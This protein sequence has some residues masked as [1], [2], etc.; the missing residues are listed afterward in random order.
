MATKILPSSLDNIISS[1]LSE[2]LVYRRINEIILT[3]IDKNAN[4]LQ[5]ST[6][7]YRLFFSDER[8]RDPIYDLF[9]LTSD[10]INELIKKVPGINSSW[11][12][13][14]DP[15]FVLMTMI[16]RSITKNDSKQDREIFHNCLMYL[17]LAMYSSLQYKYFRV[18][19]NEDI[20]E[21]TINNASNKFLFKSLGS[22]Y[23]TIEH[24]MLVSHD[25][26]RKD[27]I[28]NDD[29]RIMS[30][31]INL[32]IRFNNLLNYF[33]NEYETNRKNKN[34]INHETENYDEDNYKETT[35]ISLIIE[36]I[37]NDSTTK[38]FLREVNERLVRT[39]AETNHVDINTLKSTIESIKDREVTIKGNNVIK[40][41]FSSLIQLYLS[42]SN[43]SADTIKSKKF[44]LESMSIYNKSHSN[45]KRIIRIKEVLNEL[46]TKYCSRY[47]NTNRP[48]TKDNYKRALFHYFIM[49]ITL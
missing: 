1:K 25:K 13:A 36:N 10:E 22:V 19:P 48:R 43:N 17:S 30:Y 45:D 16:I 2:R 31:F 46:L 39:A 37:S 38:F 18:P 42:D 21:Y 35:N 34:Y 14:T 27:L 49:F 12:I 9:N 4:V 23:K 5:A 41:L 11:K 26:Y 6:P 47:V 33:K 44:I 24:T 3:F 28:S 15:F 29:L 32:R 7:S 40:D 8:E 20:M